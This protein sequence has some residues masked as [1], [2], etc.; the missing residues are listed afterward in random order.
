MV[1]S[2]VV[3]NVSIPL[4]LPRPLAWREALIAAAAAQQP[5]LALWLPV[6]LG[7]GILLYFQLWFE[8][9][10]L[11]Q[12]AFLPPLLLGCWLVGRRAWLAWGMGM[13]AALLLGFG[14]V[15]WHAGRAALPLELPRT[16]V[17][18][19]GLV[20]DIDR[21]PEGL[22]VT[23]QGA[24]WEGSAPAARHIRVRLRADE[25]F[26]PMPGQTIRLRALLRPPSAPTHPG[27]WDFQRAAWFSGLG[28]SGFALGPAMLLRD[29]GEAPALAGL[30]AE[31]EARVQASIAGPAGAIAA[32]LITGGQSA[33]PQAEMNAM[34][35][36]GLAH[37]LS[38]SGLHIAI[39]MGLGFTV[40]RAGLALWPWLALRVNVKLPASLGALALGGFYMLLT[41]AE[42]PMQRSFAMA[43]LVTLGLLIGRRALTLRG[44]AIAFAMVL[45]LQPAAIMGPSFQMS[46]A[47]VLALVAAWEWG[48]G[49]VRR[50]PGGRGWWHRAWLVFLA[51]ILTSLLA[52]AATTPFGLHHFGRLQIYGVAANALAVPLTSL[53][54][55]PSALLASLLMPFGL[56]AWPLRIMAAGVEA[57]LAIAREVAAWPGASLSATPLPGWGLGLCA[58]GMVW[59]ALWRG[60]ARA[61]GA[62]LLVIGLASG[63]A[64]PPPDALISADARLIALR[65]GQGEVFIQRA[66]GA[67]RFTRDAWLRGWGE[68][69]GAAMPEQ[70]GEAGLDC[71]GGLCRLRLTAD[72]PMLAMLRHTP[73]PP[74]GRAAGRRD[75]PPPAEA[76]CGAAEIILS[77]EPVRGRCEGSVVIDRFSVWRDG[78]HAVWLT[79][80]G[81]VV[82]SDRAARG[83]RP[84]VPPRPLPRWTPDNLPLASSE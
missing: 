54:I 36:S 31:I 40:L 20:T 82:L 48:R 1:Q 42:V 59:L 56:E 3:P 24:T 33:I 64:S 50:Q 70:G 17:M 34:R 14:L 11:G 12:A 27:A 29:G 41:G 84:W 57:V 45:A 2:L 15:G 37:L 28:G 72:G 13:L 16:A 69:E 8:P 58:L 66:S 55:M 21:L 83:D 61:A 60:P 68:A 43:A 22:R 18:V 9:S 35:D 77:P 7:C 63:S 79:A 73:P 38:V 52:G 49:Y 25:Q 76:P 32:A 10:A 81:P 71:Q 47:A 78:A 65:N 19:E 23:L 26:Q 6:A 4:H 44:L 46:F 51:S 53:L 30:R 75:T 67:T 62:A 80:A 39:V 5:H 74:R